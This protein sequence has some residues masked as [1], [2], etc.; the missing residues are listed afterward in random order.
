MPRSGVSAWIARMTSFHASMRP[1]RRSP[2]R[3]FGFAALQLRAKV[4]HRLT[5]GQLAV[6][7]ASN[8]ITAVPKL[9]EMRSLKGC[10]VTANALNGPRAIAAAK[11]IERGAHCV[12]ALKGNQTS[13]HDDARLFFE[14]PRRPASP[15]HQTVDGDNGRIETRTSTVCA[16][17]EWLSQQHKWPNLSAIGRVTRERE[18][19]DKPPRIQLIPS[20]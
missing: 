1:G 9:L 19:G 3:A 4:F 2:P 5:L 15:A 18:N 20:P 7:E 16:D 13:I 11:V 8:E 14:D 6:D 10:S 12:L 17:I